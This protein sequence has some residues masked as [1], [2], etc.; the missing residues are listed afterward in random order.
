MRLKVKMS[1][2]AV[3]HWRYYRENYE[4][5]ECQAVR[6]RGPIRR[7]TPA[8]PEPAWI[9]ADVILPDQYRGKA[10]AYGWKPDG[11]YEV[12]VPVNWNAKTLGPHLARI[13]RGELELSVAETDA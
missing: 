7:G 4:T 1:L 11:T 13:D 10:S 8:K 12:I 9:Y 3:R 5:F 2:P 6:L